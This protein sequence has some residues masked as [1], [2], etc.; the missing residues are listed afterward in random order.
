MRTIRTYLVESRQG[1]NN[2][3]WF[4][5][6]WDDNPD[7][8]KHRPITDTSRGDF[9][10]DDDNTWYPN[11]REIQN[12]CILHWPNESNPYRLI[13]HCTSLGHINNLID[14]LSYRELYDLYYHI[15]DQDDS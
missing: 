2:V 11:Y 5:G 3:T 7:K 4:L 8:Y 15:L 1:G 13:E 6:V 14:T 9:N 10:R 12:C